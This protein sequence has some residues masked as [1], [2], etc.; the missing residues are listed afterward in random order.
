MP[1]ENNKDL[2]YFITL[3]KSTNYTK[4]KELLSTAIFILLDYKRKENEMLEEL[5]KS[6][7]EK[8]DKTNE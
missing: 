4:K 7:E 6:L 5:M 2:D 1:K 3:Y 8:G